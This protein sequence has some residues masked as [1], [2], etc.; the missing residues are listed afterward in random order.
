MPKMNQP[1]FDITTGSGLKKKTYRLART[2][3]LVSSGEK[4]NLPADPELLREIALLA[5]QLSMMFAPRGSRKR[6]R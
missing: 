1:A 2:L 3:I 5:T 6:A 4:I